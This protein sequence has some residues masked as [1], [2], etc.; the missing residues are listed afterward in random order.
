M[1]ILGNYLSGLKVLFE[2]II[3]SNN[4]S[5]DVT[6]NKYFYDLFIFPRTLE[7]IFIC[8]SLGVCIIHGCALP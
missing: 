7:H 6:V 4:I 5:N 1:L 2:F 8:L 3:P